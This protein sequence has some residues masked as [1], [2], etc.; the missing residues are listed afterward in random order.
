[1]PCSR[2]LAGAGRARPDAPGAAVGLVNMTAAVTILVVTPL[3]PMPPSASSQRAD[4]E[5]RTP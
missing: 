5:R 3:V 1:M 4:L 2:A